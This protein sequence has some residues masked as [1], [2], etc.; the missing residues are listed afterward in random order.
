MKIRLT[1]NQL[2]TL[3]NKLIMEINLNKSKLYFLNEDMQHIRQPTGNSCGPTCIKMVSNFIKGN[4]KSIDDIC[5]ECGTDWVVGTP[6]DKM[7]I[8]LDYMGINYKEHIKEINPFQSLKNTIDKGNVAIVRTITKGV[9]HW[10][11]IYDYVEDTFIVNDPWLGQIKYDEDQLSDI[12]KIRDFFYFEILTGKQKIENNITIRKLSENDVVEIKSNLADVFNLTDL[13]N[14]TIWGLIS[15]SNMNKSFVAEVNGE[16]A[17]FYFIGDE[18][19]PGGGENYDILSKLKGVEG[20]ALGVFK[21]F[22]NRGIGKRLITYSQNN[23]NADYIWGYQFK[24]LKNIDDWLKRRVIYKELG[25]MYITY[26]LFKNKQSSDK[27]IT[28]ILKQL[29]SRIKN[30]YKK[31]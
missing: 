16:L 14:D 9:P 20:I 12:W 17:G 1:E 13:D 8:G 31:I 10:I 3:S 4:A 22:K 24:S 6:P 15:S 18:Q 27:K 30:K 11:V 5:I 29:I 2:K 25:D 26:E 21:K 7:R 19:I 28:N 23:L